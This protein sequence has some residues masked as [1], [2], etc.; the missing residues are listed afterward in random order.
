M[1]CVSHPFQ[2]CALLHSVGDAL[3]RGSLNYHTS[4]YN[5]LGTLEDT[6]SESEDDA[7]HIIASLATLEA[8]SNG[9]NTCCAKCAA[10][11]SS[12]SL[13][14]TV[15]EPTSCTDIYP[16]VAW[17]QW[18]FFSVMLEPWS[19]LRVAEVT[20]RRAWI[21]WGSKMQWYR[22]LSIFKW[23]IVACERLWSSASAFYFRHL[24][25]ANRRTHAA[26]Q[27]AREAKV[28]RY[29]SSHTKTS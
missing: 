17:A 28:N 2:E 15:S 1:L 4:Q 26:I 9:D 14:L 16:V 23:A 8:P 10:Y 7:R 5:N 19:K 12:Y 29:F 20:N 3:N 25:R 6:A 13:F 24:W 27:V 21:F 18:I 22:R 11:A